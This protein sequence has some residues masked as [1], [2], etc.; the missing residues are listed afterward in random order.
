[1]KKSN[2]VVTIIFVALI[3]FIISFTVYFFLVFDSKNPKIITNSEVTLNDSK[4]EYS[5]NE[6]DG[7][8][9]SSSYNFVVSASSTGDSKYKILLDDNDSTISREYVHYTL[10]L[11]GKTI[12]SGVL[13]DLRDDTLDSR[14]LTG[15]SSNTY[16]FTIWVSDD[17]S[18]NESSYYGYYLRLVPNK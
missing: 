7:E 3:I 4:K 11:N 9:N 18:L 8:T 6:I 2:L 15:K 1:M 13:S 5:L 17:A 16:I 14:I 10:V 12:K